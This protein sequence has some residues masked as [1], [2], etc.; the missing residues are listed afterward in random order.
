MLRCVGWPYFVWDQAMPRIQDVN[1][2]RTSIAEF[3][4]NAGNIFDMMFNFRYYTGQPKEYER[5]SKG[6]QDAKTH[7]RLMRKPNS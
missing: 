2:A 6:L 7:A 1:A 4:A 3:T 5:Q